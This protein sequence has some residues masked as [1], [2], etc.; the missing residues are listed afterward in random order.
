MDFQVWWLLGLPFFFFLGWLAARI[1]IRALL[2]EAQN[3]PNLYFKGLKHILKEKPDEAIQHFLKVLEEKPESYEV[4]DALGHLFSKRGDWSRAI[5]IYSRL[6][7]NEKLS[8]YHHFDAKVNLGKCFLKAGLFDRAED[9]FAE[10]KNQQEKFEISEL[11]IDL[12]QRQKE[13]EKAIQVVLKMPIEIQSKWDISL[14]HFH[15]ELAEKHLSY[16]D[17]VLAKECLSN[18]IAVNQQCVRAFAIQS[19]IFLKENRL[20]EAFSSLESIVRTPAYLPLFIKEFFK[21]YVLLSSKEKGLLLL[22]TYADQYLNHGDILVQIIDIYL[23]E[24]E[25]QRAYELAEKSFLSGPT[26]SLAD[27][28]LESKFLSKKSESNQVELAL[29]NLFKQII[30]KKVVYRCK[31]CYF[32]TQSFYWQCPC[33]H[34]WE[35]YNPKIVEV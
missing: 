29:E 24:G 32:K 3:L 13:F 17:Y 22:E 15:C 11:L 5:Q 25:Y 20:E 8:A 6:L 35:S 21:I 26:L 28:F 27:K 30:R 16:G 12:Y 34:S 14:S 2:K 10:L 4:Y 19:R 23:A 1:D 7:S 9:I 18:A 33:C 31:V